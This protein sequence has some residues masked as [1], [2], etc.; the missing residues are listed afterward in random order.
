MVSLDCLDGKDL[1]MTHYCSVGNPPH[2]R[3][4]AKASRADRLVFGCAG[5]TNLDA[6]RDGFIHD[7]TIEI[8]KD[9]KLEERWGSW[10]QGKQSEAELFHPHRNP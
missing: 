6:E 2:L 3:L 1:V 10:Y 5:G 4:D 8:G 9:G 7:A